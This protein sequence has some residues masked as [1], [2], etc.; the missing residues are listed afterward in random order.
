LSRI[1]PLE[2]NMIAQVIDLKPLEGCKRWLRLQ[3]GVSGTIDLSGALW[4]PMFEPLRDEALFA[5]VAVPPELET[6]LWPNGAELAPD[7]RYPAAKH[8]APGDAQKTARA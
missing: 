5:R 8:A 7:L 2:Q 3:G 6:L 1:D 4:G